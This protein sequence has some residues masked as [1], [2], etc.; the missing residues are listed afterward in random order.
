M[1]WA[2]LN[3]QSIYTLGTAAECER[4]VWHMVRNLGTPLGGMGA[5][6]YPQVDHIQ[7]TQANINAFSEGLTKYSNYENLPDHWWTYPV[8]DDWKD[9]EV[10]P[11][12]PKRN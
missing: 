10:P 12:L 5:Y 6:F 9:N 7:V 8:V 3:I 4:E 2:C 11:L 1:I